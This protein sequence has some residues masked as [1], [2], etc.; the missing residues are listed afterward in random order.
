VPQAGIDV[1]YVAKA[2]MR[3]SSRLRATRRA[4]G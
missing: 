1:P 4:G 3:F 2:V